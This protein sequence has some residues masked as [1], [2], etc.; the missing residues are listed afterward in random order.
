MKTSLIVLSLLLVQS[1]PT[2]MERPANEIASIYADIFRKQ[3]DPYLKRFVTL[4]YGEP[5]T[6]DE[7][8]LAGVEYSAYAQKADIVNNNF[9]KFIASQKAFTNDEI[10]RQ[11]DRMYRYEFPGLDKAF[12]DN[13]K[14]E[15]GKIK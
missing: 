9:V 8:L 14:K 3:I 12:F 13:V 5:K 6:E 15:I 2:K 7:L 10:Y 1:L 4:Q 11:L